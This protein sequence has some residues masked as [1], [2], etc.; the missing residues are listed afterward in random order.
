AYVRG[1][2]TMT[3]AFPGAPAVTDKGKYVEIHKKQA[4][5][6]WKVKYDSWS[7]DLPVPGLAIATGALKADASAELKQLDLLVGTW[8]IDGESKAT[9]DKPSAKTSMMLSCRWLDGGAHI[10]CQ[11]EGA[12]PAGPSHKVDFYGYDAASKTYTLSYVESSGLVGS[13]KLT[14]DKNTW[15]HV[16]D[17]KGGPKPMKLR[18]TLTN[19]T[20]ASG[21][22]KDDLAVA[23]GPWAAVAEGKY[24]KMK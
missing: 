6:T 15:T 13:G 7:S 14:I 5:G 3:M 2:Y 17:I 12:G 8:K 24:V 23:G 10:V 4:D 19:M 18:L 20:P 16:W 1:N 11:Y 9:K 21:D 22:W